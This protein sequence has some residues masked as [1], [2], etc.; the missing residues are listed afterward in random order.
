MTW[1]HYNTCNTEPTWS[2]SFSSHSLSNFLS[3]ALSCFFSAGDCLTDP[4]VGWNVNY[5]SGWG[6]SR[7][8]NRVHLLVMTILC[9]G[10]L[11][12]LGILPMFYVSCQQ[13]SGSWRLLYFLSSL[14]GTLFDGG[15]FKLTLKFTKEY[16]VKP[17]VVPFVS[18]MFHRN[19]FGDGSICLD[20][21]YKTWSGIVIMM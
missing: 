21:T 9:F 1:L 19:I 8:F 5:S 7:G 6:I 20:I 11:L 2:F 15:I 17:P 3:L 16:P 13:C 12:L 18:R 4:V 14:G 10:T